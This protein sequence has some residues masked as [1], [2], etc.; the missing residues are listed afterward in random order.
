MTL[1]HYWANVVEVVTPHIALTEDS[2]LS[3]TDWVIM[4]LHRDEKPNFS[5]LSASLTIVNSL[6]LIHN[7]AFGDKSSVFGVQEQ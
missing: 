4:V 6:N 3:G 7:F 1:I 5:P 2:E